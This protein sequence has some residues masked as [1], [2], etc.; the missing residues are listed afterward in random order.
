MRL[1]IRTVFLGL[2]GMTLLLAIA[3]PVMAQEG[4]V[5]SGGGRLRKLGRGVANIAT[6]PLELLRTPEFVG[7]K[8]GYVSAVTIGVLQGLWRTVLRGVVG[9][10]EVVTFYAEI[11]RDYEPLMHPEFVWAHGGWVE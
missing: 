2:V 10:F 9:V 1:K 6:C 11:P 5:W 7:R 4:P 3:S 8:E